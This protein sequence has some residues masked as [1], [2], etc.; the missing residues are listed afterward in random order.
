L[1]TF[2][3]K[4]RKPSSSR[5][6]TFLVDGVL[7]DAVQRRQQGDAPRGVEAQQ[8]AALEHLECRDQGRAGAR[9]GLD[10]GDQGGLGLGDGEAQHAFRLGAAENPAALDRL[11]AVA[12][13]DVPL[14]PAAAPIAIAHLDNDRLEVLVDPV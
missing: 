2:T 12:G 6:S 8:R 1:P 9:A 14:A 7:G 11:L 4:V 10:A 3:L 13:R 5:C